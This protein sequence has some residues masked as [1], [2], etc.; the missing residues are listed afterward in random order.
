[1]SPDAA[2]TAG[3]SRPRVVVVGG[4][5]AGLATVRALKDAPVSILLIDRRN[6]HIFQPLLY[7]VAT[8]MLPS[9]DIAVPIREVVR[10]QSNT[11][12]AMAEVIGVDPDRRQVIAW[13]PDGGEAVVPYEYL[14]LATGV[15]QSYFGHDEFARF[16]PGLK[17]LEDAG[18]IRSKLLRAYESAETE[19]EPSK[20]R[21]LLSVVLVGAGPTGAEL[22]GTIAGMA[23]VTLKANFRRIDPSQTRVILVDNGPRILATFAEDL[24]RKAHDRL[25]QLGVEI[26][27]GS[28]VD[29]V[30]EQGVIVSGQRIPSRTVLWT[31][32]VKPSPAGA[33][34]RT[35][36]DRGGRV[37]VQPDLSA[38][39]R[40]EVFAIGDTAHLE[41]NGK[42][43]PGVAQVALQQGRYV[44]RVIASRIA[45]QPAP[46]PFKYSDRGNMAIIGKKFAILESGKVKLSGLPALMAWAGIHLAYLP[47][48]GSRFDVLTRWLFT[49]ATG[50]RGSRVILGGPR[51]QQNTGSTVLPS[52]ASTELGLGRHG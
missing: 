36:T 6:H 39:G 8:A 52:A 35:E 1:M 24:S 15:E 41:Q 19:I 20:H 32:G 17:S 37:A 14:V 46:P 40:P 42:P 44:A 2:T 7:Q 27:T 26:R 22:A 12:V 13:T 18:E 50:E 5:F 16:A 31:A 29:M 23:K 25:T 28:H 49:Y 38:R 48:T 10:K 34:V 43:L 11:T 45:G 4:G 51:H 30:D 3:G 47:Q 33:W 21:D 9:G